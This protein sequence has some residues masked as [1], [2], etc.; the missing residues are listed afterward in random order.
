MT[1]DYETALNEFRDASAAVRLAFGAITQA[2]ELQIIA[3]SQHN[4]AH[5]AHAQAVA[6]LDAADNALRVSREARAAVDLTPEPVF[7]SFAEVQTE[8]VAQPA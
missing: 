4:A 6:R 3:D 5:V 1:T 8:I 7:A 2:R